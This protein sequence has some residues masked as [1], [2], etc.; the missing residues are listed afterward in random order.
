MDRIL[1]AT[2]LTPK[3][4]N[5][6]GRAIRLAARTGASLCILHATSGSEDDEGCPASH[7]RIR[8]EAQIM[9]EALTEAP[10][11]ISVRISGHSPAHAIIEEADRLDADIIVLGGHGTPR[12]RDALFGTTG[13]HVVRNACRPVLV[14]QIDH[15]APYSKV[16]LAVPNGT[17]TDLIDAAI[18]AAPDAQL[19]A[20]HAFSPSLGETLAGSRA[21]DHLEIGQERDLEAAMASAGRNAGHD[22]VKPHATVRTGE[23]LSVLMEEAEK[24]EPDL[25]VMGTRRRVAYLGSHAVDTLFWCPCDILVVP[26]PLTVAA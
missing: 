16:M 21:L 22:T 19:H 11:D 14:V 1:I 4:S 23:P 25:L 9:A 15:A 20:V 17:A 26:E 24:I 10:L 7:R 6:L 2:D 12:F 5:A 3:S 8:T 13:T 18:G